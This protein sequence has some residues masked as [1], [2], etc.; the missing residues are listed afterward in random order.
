MRKRRKVS[1]KVSSNKIEIINL[2]K[3]LYDSQKSDNKIIKENKR[4]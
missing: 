1:S 4:K 2:C 3:K